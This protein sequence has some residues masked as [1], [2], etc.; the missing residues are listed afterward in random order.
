MT[1]KN[2]QIVF[3][4]LILITLYIPQ[5]QILDRIGWQ[6]LF[7][8]LVNLGALFYNLLLVF[9]EKLKPLKIPFNFKMFILLFFWAILSLFYTSSIQITV[10]DL[11]RFYIY[12]ITFFN[13]LIV[14]NELKITFKRLS[15]LFTILF[16]I[17][18]YF[19]YFSLFEIISQGL[20]KNNISNYLKGIASNVNI[21]SF[22]ISLKVPFL[23]YL[24]Y[25]EENNFFKSTYLFLIVLGYVM[26]NF[27]DSRA[28]T[29]SNYL[30]LLI[31]L[32]F[33]IF[34]LNK[35]ILIKSFILIFTIFLSYNLPSYIKNGENDMNKELIAITSSSKNDDS[36]NQRL[37]YYKAGIEQISNNP[38]MGVG[39]GNWKLESIKYDKDA[40][41]QY[42]V[43]Y[44]MHND[45]LQ[46]GAELG[47]IG[48]V[49]YLLFF[50]SS[51][52]KYLIDFKKFKI[53]F[54]VETLASL[55]FF[56][57]IFID[58]NLNF[59]FAR[60]MIFLQ[61]L[62]FISYLEIKQNKTLP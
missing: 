35:K 43:P 5:Y 22:S 36:K 41:I 47:L 21:T 31:I 3:G 11:S 56:T 61:F 34:S 7:L 25:K 38:I 44:H 13:L 37:R 14:L 48:F 27:L 55:L 50:C 62:F 23:I 24:F 32:W 1:K 53:L 42:I 59:P 57:Y 52:F 17:E 18:I 4:L 26:L 33:G 45:F 19:S 40:S 12:I 54:N 10:I 20:F 9:K 16:I 15:Y 51:F 30:I 6:W 60:P 58:S 29:L 28:I 49:L 8:C 46:I 2:I 39:F